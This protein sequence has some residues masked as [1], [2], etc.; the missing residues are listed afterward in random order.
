MKPCCSIGL[1][2]SDRFSTPDGV[3]G[4]P[5][6]PF[7]GQLALGHVPI[8]P[9]RATLTGL[10]LRSSAPLRSILPRAMACMS[11]LMTSGPRPSSP[12]WPPST[13]R[14]ASASPA[15]NRAGFRG[16]QFLVGIEMSGYHSP[17]LPAVQP[18]GSRRRIN[19]AATSVAAIRDINHFSASRST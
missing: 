3:A 5:R 10:D 6:M 13:G 7:D 12:T 16:R 8:V 14:A 17:H 1:I 9:D 4:V 15:A 11:P 2:C 19:H 18:G